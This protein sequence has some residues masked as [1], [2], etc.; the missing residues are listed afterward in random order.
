MLIARRA[1]ARQG[2]SPNR[3]TK[4]LKVEVR[5]GAG[6][7]NKYIWDDFIGR[8]LGPKWAAAEKVNHSGALAVVPVFHILLIL[9]MVLIL[10]SQ[11]NP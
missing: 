9:D 1:G 7:K 8:Q 2:D 6:G 11:T 3:V 4:P 5:R 10:S